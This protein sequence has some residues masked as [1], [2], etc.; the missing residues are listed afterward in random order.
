MMSVIAGSGGSVAE[1]KSILDAVS[2]PKAAKKALEEFETLIKANEKL[3]AEMQ[4]LDAEYG[5]KSKKLAEEKAMIDAQFQDLRKK[6]ADLEGREKSLV[7]KM[8][9]IKSGESHLAIA[10][11]DLQEKKAEL[12]KQIQ[13][14][15]SLCA[16]RD[17]EHV[18]A[19]AHAKSV[20]DEF[21]AKIAKLKQAIG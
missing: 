1:L 5:P 15:S 6:E 18:K 11:E 13:D 4:K 9:A 21:E 14:F 20:K 3:I 10:R 2:D 16:K 19:M 17:A 7:S 12:E 8:S